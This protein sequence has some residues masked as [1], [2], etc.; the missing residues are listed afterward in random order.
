MEISKLLSCID[1]EGICCNQLRLKPPFRF[2]RS[3]TLQLS[4]VIL[5]SCF[6]FNSAE[7]QEDTVYH[8][9]VVDKKTKKVRDQQTSAIL[10]PPPDYQGW[11][12]N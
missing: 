10:L 7:A 3:I 9:Y 5:L 4:F 1:K 2:S 8:K 12:D 11:Y 6:W